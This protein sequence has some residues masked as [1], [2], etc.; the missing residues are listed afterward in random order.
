MYLIR[1]HHVFNIHEQINI[2]PYALL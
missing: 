2:I 1:L